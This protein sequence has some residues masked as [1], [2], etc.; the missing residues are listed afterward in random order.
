MWAAAM[1]E[2][3]LALEVARVL[4]VAGSFACL[5]LMYRAIKGGLEDEHD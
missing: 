3:L 1:T 5:V 4:A 2:S